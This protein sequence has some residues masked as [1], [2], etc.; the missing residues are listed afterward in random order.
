MEQGN[1]LAAAGRGR[2]G[3]RM[4][5]KCLLPVFGYLGRDKNVKKTR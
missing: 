1:T 5:V 2:G 3:E 4:C